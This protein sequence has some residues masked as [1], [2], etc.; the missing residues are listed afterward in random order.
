M[1][2][3]LPTGVITFLFTDIEGS[4]G[5]WQRHPEQMRANLLRHDR[6]LRQEIEQRQGCVFKTVGDAFCAAFQSAAPGLQAAMAMQRLLAG[7]D[8]GAAPIRVRMGLH[9]GEADERDGDYFGNSL[10]RVARLMSAGH[11]GQILLSLAT[12]ELLPQPPEDTR[13][14]DLG[15]HRLKGLLEPEHIFQVLAPG[16][17]QEFPALN[18]LDYR[19]NNL[20]AQ[21]T[22]FLGREAELAE[23]KKLLLDP[24]VRMLTLTGPGGAGK[25][26][27]AL[28]A[29]AEWMDDFPGGVFFVPLAAVG[30]PRLIL[31]A[32]AQALEVH[33]LPGAPLA[34]VK[35]ALQNQRALLILDN[36]EQISTAAPIL[37]ELL[38]ALPSVKLLCTSRTLLHVYGEHHYP[39]PPLHLPLRPDAL[40]VEDLAR[41]EAVRFFVHKAQIAQPAFVLDPENAAVIAEICRRLDGLPLALELAAARLRLL[42]PAALLAQLEHRL[43]LLTGG[44]RDL[45]ARQQTLRGA[46]DWSY[47]L[48]QQ[49]EQSLFQ[50]LAIFAGSFN[51]E[52]AAGV[53]RLPGDAPVFDLLE[54]LLDKSLLKVVDSG[55][56]LRFQM[57]ETLREYALE[58]L[59]AEGD[60]PAASTLH[61][62]FYLGWAEGIAP[63]LYR[64]K[65]PAFLKQIEIDQANLQAALNWAVEN[66]PAAGLRLGNALFRFWLTRP[67]YIHDALE[68]L[69]K[70]LLASA[71]LQ[72][73]N[74]AWALFHAASL[75]NYL[76]ASWVSEKGRRWQAESMILAHALSD[77]VLIARALEMEGFQQL[78]AENLGAAE[79]LLQQSLAAARL[80]GDLPGIAYA[81]YRLGEVALHRQDYALARSQIEDSLA[82]LKNLGELRRWGLGLNLLGIICVQQGDWQAAQQYCTEAIQLAQEMQDPLNTA[83][84]LANLGHIRLGLGEFEPAGRLFEQARKIV[85]DIPAARPF[86]GILKGLGEIARFQGDIESAIARFQ[87]S[88]D[89]SRDEEFKAIVYCLAGCAELALGK[90]AAARLRIK[91][92]LQIYKE[93]AGSLTVDIDYVITCT[94]YIAVSQGNMRLAAV[95]LGWVQQWQEAHSIVQAPVY[96]AELE[97]YLARVQGSLPIVE[98]NAA[99]AEAQTI[100]VEQVLAHA[101]MVLR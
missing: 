89:A 98:F 95:L 74:R 47:N 100:N 33:N 51:L 7:A 29:A 94:A 26:R 93:L 9:T 69:E 71:A 86:P 42:P 34:Q 99:Q 64:R 70:L 4:T 63:E 17:T 96:Q 76:S 37:G 87:E 46:I 44:A 50:Q 24:A 45:P 48:L 14:K 15:L 55:S 58:K 2:S 62:N 101:E 11:G 41:C 25:T 36:L 72:D 28:Q 85:Q 21:A 60:L 56:E 57:L 65:M 92:A 30:E 16:L 52:A 81:A 12:R 91:S 75:S 40:A 31:P 82:I 22:P 77:P 68:R 1:Y 38:A 10:N 27:L 79:Q 8:W 53:C 90:L 88:L 19:P 73:T 35:V 6:L 78:M 20:P 32:I 80:A 13:F 83:A 18:T 54:Q 59:A 97:D 84:Y 66:D 23:I 3:S 61:L 39:L 43:R 67:E 5:L 49:Q